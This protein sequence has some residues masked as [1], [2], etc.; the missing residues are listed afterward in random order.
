MSFNVGLLSLI[1][2]TCI[3]PNLKLFIVK[4]QEEAVDEDQAEAERVS[5]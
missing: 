3:N 2:H 5:Y 4:V 1:S